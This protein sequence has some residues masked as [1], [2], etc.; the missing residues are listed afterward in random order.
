MNSQ[1]DQSW[2][3]KNITPVLA[4]VFTTMFFVIIMLVLTHQVKA[5]D[6]N[7]SS[8]I[9]GMF[10]VVMMII[11][12]YFGS[13][14]KSAVKQQETVDKMVDNLT[15]F[16]IKESIVDKFTTM[17]REELEAFN[18]EMNLG[19]IF[20]PNETDDDIKNMIRETIKNKGV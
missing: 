6:T 7:T 17:T 10:G 13:S 20:L 5:N 16:K 4:L 11:G 18:K 15:A 1:T 2:L 19:L 3:Q 12:Y 8:I 9:T 14:S